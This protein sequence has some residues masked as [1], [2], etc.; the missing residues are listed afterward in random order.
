MKPISHLKTLN[1]HRR[2]VRQG[3]FAVGL[4]AQGLLHDLSKYSPSEF[5]VGAKYYQGYRS[6][7]NAEREAQGYS[8][9]WLHHKG[10]NKH[11]YEYW[12]DYAAS[13]GIGAVPVRMPDRYL[14]EMLMDRIAASKTYN[15]A[16][17]TNDMPLQYFL[18]GKPIIV[19]HEDSKRALEF[20]LRMLAEKGEAETFAYI[21]KRILHNENRLRTFEK[22]LKRIIPEGHR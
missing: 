2:L 12:V 21:R 4:Y 18:K 10:R 15:G 22:I 11:H 19:M 20:L 6:P 14:V 1:A 3:C 9:A 7:N 16:N 5:L 17:Y 13:E 8:A